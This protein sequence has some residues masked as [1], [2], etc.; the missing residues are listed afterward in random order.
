MEILHVFGIHWKLLLAQVVNFSIALFVL[1]RFVYRPIFKI[2]AEREAMIHKGL[3]DAKQAEADRKDAQT[4]RDEILLAA[5]QEGGRLADELHKKGVEEE[6]RIVREANDK[7][8]TIL[9]EAQLR[10]KEEH[11][12]MLKKGEEDMAKMAIL[13]AEKILRA[14]LAKN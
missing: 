2:L 12:Y 13:A 14:D 8:M 11:A 3:D 5:R 10:A 9:A 7:S 1:Y 6:R 4:G